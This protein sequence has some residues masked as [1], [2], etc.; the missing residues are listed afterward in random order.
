MS[1][2]LANAALTP[3]PDRSITF[4]EQCP[5]TR[6]QHSFTYNCDKVRTSES[7]EVC[8]KRIRY[9]SPGKIS[10]ARSRALMEVLYKVI[11]WERG[12]A[13]EHPLLPALGA[14]AYAKK[15]NSN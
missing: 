13:P 11:A 6:Q 12:D 1:L 10:E 8:V 3:P 9:S 5:V 15:N 2:T 14:Y 7:L 4:A